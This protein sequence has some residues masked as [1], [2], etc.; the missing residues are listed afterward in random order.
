MLCLD[1]QKSNIKIEKVRGG[2]TCV[3]NVL[4]ERPNHNK[5][6]LIAQ[7]PWC[8]D[9]AR[10]G[11]PPNPAPLPGSTSQGVSLGH[12]LAR[13]ARRFDWLDFDKPH[14]RNAVAALKPLR[15]H[16]HCSNCLVV[17]NAPVENI[18]DVFRDTRPRAVVSAS[19]RY[20][21]AEEICR[22]VGI[23]KSIHPIVWILRLPM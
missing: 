11:L 22:S 3:P 7:A 9:G 1:R 23:L 19:H 12:Q 14:Y 18:R 16:R 5:G 13:V 21:A 8:G 10:L 2:S 4:G 17:L 20:V 6:V 15:N